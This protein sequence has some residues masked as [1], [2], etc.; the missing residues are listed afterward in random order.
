MNFYGEDYWIKSRRSWETRKNKL[1]SISKELVGEDFSVFS[2]V[3][4]FSV[5]TNS[6]SIQSVVH[7]SLD[8]HKLSVKDKKYLDL[9]MRLAEAYE[10][11]Y[12]KEV[13]VKK[14]YPEW[15]WTFE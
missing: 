6:F 9:A 8:N 2:D 1:V 11:F 4:S 7:Y 10:N 13:T 3:E 5:C 15:F 14:D 12:G